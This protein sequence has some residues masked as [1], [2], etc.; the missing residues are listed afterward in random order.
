MSGTA[1][2]Q[3]IGF[4]LTPIIS[5]L[6]TPSDFGIFGSFNSVLGVI[7]AG[8][9]LQ[10]TQA[11]MLPKR[12]EDAANIF[13]VSMLSVF[14][15]TLV[16]LLS[17]YFFSDWLLGILKAPQS[18]GLLWLLPL[19]VFLSGTNQ[20]FQAW[21]IRRK[22]F[23]ATSVSQ[24]VRSVVVSSSQI[25]LGVFK[26]GG[27]GLIVGS[28][29]AEGIA[30]LNLARQT[31]GT[32]KVLL[33]SSLA[34]KHIRRLAFEY[35]DFPI[36]AATQQLMN[37]LSQGLPVLLLSHF[38]GIAVAGSYAF[39]VRLL[40]VPMNFVLTSLRQ[41]LFQKA[42]ET[43]NQNGDLFTLFKKTTLGLF[44]IA[45][46]PA[47]VLI[48]TAPILFSWIFGQNWYQAGILTRWLVVWQLSSFCN[49][50]SAILSRIL[51]LQRKLFFFEIITLSS[52]FLVLLVGGFYLDVYSVV[53]LFSALG[54]MLNIAMILWIW[55][56]LKSSNRWG[57]VTDKKDVIAASDEIIK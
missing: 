13:A 22:A 33:K 46:I 54:M 50:P 16:G 3:V 1:V 14:V 44:V 38:Y 41:V 34:W 24:V 55:K 27:L 40:Q 5:R 2:A 10:Y 56:V 26:A 47:S 48:L 52:R 4:A 32:D 8:V 37:T 21:C 6:F 9:T 25:I 35:R 51:R 36:Y 39:G 49:V 7:T 15:I 28:V 30:S 11:I 19:S 45:V 43:H 57:I 20:S 42:C 29:A 12:H 18:T 17:A 31:L 23:S 53:A